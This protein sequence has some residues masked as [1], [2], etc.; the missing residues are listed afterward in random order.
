MRAFSETERTILRMAQGD[1]PETA[2]PYAEIARLA[3]EETGTEVGEDEVLALLAELKE[4]G[5]I[6]RF[7][8][9]LRHQKAG[10]GYN[11]MVAWRIDDEAELHRM[12]E[13]FAANDAVSHCYHRPVQ[14]DWNY[15]LF[16]MVHAR[17]PEE[18]RAIV[19]A[20][21]KTLAETLGIVVEAVDFAVLKSIKELKKTSMEYF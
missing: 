14:G 7:G 3:S 8:A 9:T 4:A 15:G 12:G 5:A 10:Y 19:A 1:L 20:M 11:A 17:S 18:N 13:I 2:T 6:R 16:T 21:A